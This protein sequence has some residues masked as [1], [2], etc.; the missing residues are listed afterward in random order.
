MTHRAVWKILDRNTQ[1][2]DLYGTHHRGKEMKV[3]EITY[4]QKP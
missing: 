4:T 2:F 3:M 1:T